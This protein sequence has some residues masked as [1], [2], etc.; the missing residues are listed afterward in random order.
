MTSDELK[1]STAAD[2][3][4]NGWLR[5]VAIQLAKLNEKNPAEQQQKP[6]KGR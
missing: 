3:S 2:M 4:T 6:Q 1:A 5:E